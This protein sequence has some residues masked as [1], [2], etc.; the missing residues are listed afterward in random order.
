[1]L[2]DI[3]P[4]LAV[5]QGAAVQASLCAKDSAVRDVVLTDVTP[6]SLG[7]EIGRRLPGG[8]VEEGY[9]S[10]ILERNTTLPASRSGI[11][12]P[13]EEDQDAIDLQVYQGEHRRVEQN[14]L[15]GKLEIK[16]LRPRRGEG[17]D[18]SVEVRFTHDMNGILEVEAKVLRTGKVHQL[19]IEQRPGHLSRK[20]L[21]A[22][23][24]RMQPLKT[25]PRDLLPNRARLE[26]AQ[27]LY[28]EL[29][30]D[31]RRLLTHVLEVFEDAL[32]T[33]EP[34]RIAEA[35]AQLD[36]VVGAYFELEGEAQPDA[37]NADSPPDDV[38]PVEGP[39]K[40]GDRAEE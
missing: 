3:D 32:E 33:Q 37:A 4:D 22:C 8:R 9:F 18:S 13:F 17:D 25:H 30:G 20:E 24:K 36:R 12:S 27:R 40:D 35:G 11:Y 6:F 26:R 38:E 10:P 28:T 5:A 29:R 16:G 19:V 14:H 15:L 7:V 23:L 34:E 1:M 39:W 21:A 2:T 31:R